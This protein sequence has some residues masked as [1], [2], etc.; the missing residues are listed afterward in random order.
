MNTEYIEGAEVRKYVAALEARLR[1]A[2]RQRDSYRDEFQKEQDRRARY[3]SDLESA[4]R[5]EGDLRNH[6]AQVTKER[7]AMK[8]DLSIRKVVDPVKV[9]AA[10]F[11][12]H[13]IQ[14]KLLNAA[15]SGHNV[16]VRWE[17][18]GVGMGVDDYDSPQRVP[19]PETIITIRI[20]E[21]V[22]K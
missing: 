5:A 19:G 11:A 20:Q 3:Q 13:G 17:R 8:L 12:C 14:S 9:R 4:L 1:G 7:D 21:E 2:E 16:D 15:L 18:P 22:G 10:V 6:L